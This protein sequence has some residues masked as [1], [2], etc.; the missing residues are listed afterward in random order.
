MPLSTHTDTPFQTY[1]EETLDALLDK[2]GFLLMLGTAEGTVKLATSSEVAIGVLAKKNPGDIAVQVTSLGSGVI[3]RGRAGGAIAKGAKVVW[4]TGG[5]FAAVSAS[6]GTYKTL[7][8]KVDQA[9]NADND[10]FE[11]LTEKE[12]VIVS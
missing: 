1:A 12:T 8:I 6:A 10:F 4:A 9:T 3:A 11:F 7:G 2:E 5:K